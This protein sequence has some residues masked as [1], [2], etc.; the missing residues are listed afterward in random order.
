MRPTTVIHGEV[1]QLLP[2]GDLARAIGRSV[3]HV[4]LLEHQGVLPPA[5]ARRRVQGHRGW[6]LY[7]ADYVA[8]VAVIAAEERIVS[9]KSVNDMTS[10][11]QRAWAAHHAIHATGG[12]E[13]A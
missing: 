7:R 13:P 2:I 6:R 3:G 5:H 8:A 9:R 4:R 11:K 10:F 1:V 12:R